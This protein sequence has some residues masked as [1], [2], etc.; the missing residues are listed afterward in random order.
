[1]RVGRRYSAHSI[2]TITLREPLASLLNTPVTFIE[3]GVQ[4][5]ERIH[6]ATALLNAPIRHMNLELGEVLS[7]GKRNKLTDAICC[8][9]LL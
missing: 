3:H 7:F 4:R 9:L 8:L 2:P 6:V 1:M 5:R